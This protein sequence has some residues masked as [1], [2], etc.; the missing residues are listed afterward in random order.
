[1]AWFRYGVIEK[2]L[3]EVFRVQS[4]QISAFRSQLRHLRNIN[5]PK[6]PKT[7]SGQRVSI[8]REQAIEIMI[9]LEL[10]GLGVAPR[11]AVEAAKFYAEQISDPNRDTVG[12]GDLLIVTSRQGYG[13]PE[14][15]RLSPVHL[16]DADPGSLVYA[17]ADLVT[18]LQP[19]SPSLINRLLTGG[20]FAVVN[21]ARSIPLLDRAL[22]RASAGAPASTR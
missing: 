20:T 21:V 6:L 12:R 13:G 4:D 18:S 7:G 15:P 2:A 17:A 8:T 14:G 1:V 10:A 9:A 16:T 3:A 5:C 19:A 11:H 22:K